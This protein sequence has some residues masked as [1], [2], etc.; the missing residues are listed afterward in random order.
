MD[1]RNHEH[2]IILTLA[3]LSELEVAIELVV[4][5]VLVLGAHRIEQSACRRAKLRLSSAKISLEHLPVPQ[6]PVFSPHN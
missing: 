1:L 4:K 3:L 6:G 2:T 5:D